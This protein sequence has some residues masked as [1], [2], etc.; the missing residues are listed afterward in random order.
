MIRST[1]LISPQREPSP[2]PSGARDQTS[3][4]FKAL[5]F[6]CKCNLFSNRFHQLLRAWYFCSNVFSFWILL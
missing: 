2:T 3:F 5:L 4:S 1:E 6:T